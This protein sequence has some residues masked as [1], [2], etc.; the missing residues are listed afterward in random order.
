MRLSE[1]KTGQSCFCSDGYYH[2]KVD[3]PYETRKVKVLGIRR[4]NREK[5]INYS[6]V[7]CQ[8]EIS[9]KTFL[10]DCYFLTPYDDHLAEL[11]MIEED[12][13]ENRRSAGV[14]L[15]AAGQGVDIT[16]GRKATRIQ[17][18]EQAADKL[19][20]A[21]GAK[22]LPDNRR[23]SLCG[24]GQ[25]NEKARLATLLSRR[26]ARALGGGGVPSW[27]GEYLHSEGDNFQAR[28]IFQA[29]D[30]AAAAQTLS[31]GRQPQENPSALGEMLG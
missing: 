11:K 1:V 4:A 12:I 3:S 9:G 17:F 31:G 19:L 30:I 21:C 15:A 16:V 29:A 18:T 26:L 27:T 23:P 28:I 25:E 2:Y 20:A 24:P 6:L 8:E 7:Q 22:P 5:G 10:I 14:I 13:E